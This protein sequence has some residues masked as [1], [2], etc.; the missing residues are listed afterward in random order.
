MTG[1]SREAFSF[2]AARTAGVYTLVRRREDGRVDHAGT[3]G[4]DHALCGITGIDV[5]RQPFDPNVRN[6]CPECREEAARTPPEPVVS[7]QERLHEMLEPA[8]GP[9]RDE[10][11]RLLRAGAHVG[12]WTGGHAQTLAEGVV[13]DRIIEG[14]D[15]IRKALAAAASIELIRVKGGGRN[16]LVVV[17]RGGSPAVAVQRPDPDQSPETR[18]EA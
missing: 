16:F 9:L 4:N 18:D 7:I 11:R 15:A 14:A 1:D 3:S 2:A 5:Y 13:F 17:P 6:V 12:P 8:E 10:L